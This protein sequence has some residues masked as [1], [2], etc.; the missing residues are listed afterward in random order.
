M[1]I[2]LNLVL[3]DFVFVSRPSYGKVVRWNCTNTL[4]C[5]YNIL[6]AV[7]GLVNLKSL[8]HNQHQSF[9]NK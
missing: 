3:F 8:I 7:V 1:D 5:Q 4:R 6:G 9:T 2:E